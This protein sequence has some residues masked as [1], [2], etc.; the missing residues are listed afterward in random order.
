MELSTTTLAIFAVF[1]VMGVVGVVAIEVISTP[2]EATARGCHSGVPFNASQGR[3][4]HP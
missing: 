1:A 4:F 3:C 2:Q